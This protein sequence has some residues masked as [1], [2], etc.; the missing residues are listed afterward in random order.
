MSAM[1]SK[2]EFIDVIQEEFT[3]AVGD[4]YIIERTIVSKNN[5]TEKVGLMFKSRAGDNIN[6][7]PVFY[8]GDHYTDYTSGALVS[9]IVKGVLDE[10]SLTFESR[11]MHNT[12]FLLDF[13]E[14]KDKIIMSVVSKERNLK[15]LEELPYVDY[16][17]LAII[18]LI[19]VDKHDGGIYSAKIN[20]SIL[21]TWNVKEEQLLPLAIKN[22][23]NLLP[24][25][26]YML[27]NVIEEMISGK[28]PVNILLVKERMR[29]NSSCMFML[30][31]SVRIE[32][33]S[34]ILYPGLL[35]QVADMLNG[36]LIVIPSSIHEILITRFDE[37]FNL[38][39]LNL[40]V[41][42]VNKN[43]VRDEDILSNTPYLYRRATDELVIV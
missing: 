35:K 7:A 10:L 16:L 17:N 4:S 18:F 38:S 15:L 40:I 13:E 5:C 2:E 37:S 8:I 30:T 28:D 20:K 26:L 34:A 25:N 14:V 39:E 43:D 27:D 41:R 36:D 9:D 11:V 3:K 23:V 29:Y 22:S 32:G 1:L 31:N 12:K 24:P 42:D 6:A 19:F 21:K 33:A